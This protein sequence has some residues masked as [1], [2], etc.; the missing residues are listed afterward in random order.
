MKHK[1][2]KEIIN[3]QEVYVTVYDETIDKEP[4]L[5]TGAY[6]DEL[7][8]AS[9]ERV[10]EIKAIIAQYEKDCMNVILEDKPNEEFLYVPEE[11]MLEEE[12]FGDEE[13]YMPLDKLLEKLGVD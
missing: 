12:G 8:S 10:E 3:G 11:D 4:T 13:S 5:A 1:K 9:P 6:L 2:R 7:V